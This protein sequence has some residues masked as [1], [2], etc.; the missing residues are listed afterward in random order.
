MRGMRDHYCLSLFSRQMVIKY[1]LSCFFSRR[2]V[3]HGGVVVVLLQA[4]LQYFYSITFLNAVI[5]R[6][7]VE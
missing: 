1:M 3:W 6:Q 2:A 4:A 7:A 5:F